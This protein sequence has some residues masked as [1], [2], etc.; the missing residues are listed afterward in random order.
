MSHLYVCI[1]AMRRTFAVLQPFASQK[2]FEISGNTETVSYWVSEKLAL[3]LKQ[4]VYF[5]NFI[6]VLRLILYF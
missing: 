1:Y 5:F 6:G 3:P 4:H 2:Y